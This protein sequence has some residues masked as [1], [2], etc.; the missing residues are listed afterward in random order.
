[1]CLPYKSL[2]VK[3]DKDQENRTT[4]FRSGLCKHYQKS[5][6]KHKLVSYFRPQKNLPWCKVR[7]KYP[8]HY[9]IRQVHR[10]IRLSDSSRPDRS[11]GLVSPYGSRRQNARGHSVGGTENVVTC[12]SRLIPQI[13]KDIPNLE[14]NLNLTVK[15]GEYPMR[16]T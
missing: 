6:I 9:C 12:R 4:H 13:Q 5:N 10:Q 8:P 11:R 1:M 7:G 14:D 2:L 3:S 15:F 16:D